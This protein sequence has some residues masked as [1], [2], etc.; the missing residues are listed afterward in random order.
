MVIDPVVDFKRAFVTGATGMVGSALCRA[1]VT[2]G[3]VVTAYS[4]SAGNARLPEG[5]IGVSG[6][7]LDVP[8]LEIAA[9]GSEVIFHVAAA[10][11]GSATTFAEFERMNV[12][13]TKNVIRVASKNS[14][15]LVHVSTVNVESF[16][17]GSLN[18]AY[19]ATKSRAEELV[20]EAV[21][22]GLQVV[23]IRPAMVFGEAVGTAGLIV[24]RALKGA[25]K[26]LPAPGRV[27]SPVWSSD[28]ARALIAASQVTESGRIYTIAGPT[29]S[30]GNFVREVC[31]SAG[32]K[33][34]LIMIP[35]WIIVVPLQIAWWLKQVTHWT[36]TISVVS[37]LSG[38]SY[39]GRP[40]AQELN[41][42]YSSIRE[43]F[44]PTKL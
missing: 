8:A 29:M 17:N 40:A 44:S 7:I 30:T 2:A 37:L 5:V 42:K 33:Q 16:R 41:F 20:F 35:S 4:R 43:I 10:V 14:A 39:D 12:T 22:E 15:K 25:L 27:I 26:I 13:G 6:D 32:I 28:L 18:D 19:A 3:V 21:A 38:S 34:P 1:L 31:N 11:H 23:I 9:E 36:P 24:D